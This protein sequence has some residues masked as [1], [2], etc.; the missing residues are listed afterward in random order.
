MT[1]FIIEDNEIEMENLKVL[2]EGFGGYSLIGSADEIKQGIES[3]NCLK[4][5][6][7]VLDIQLECE[8][9]LDH[10]GSL[11]YEPFIIC[12]TLHTE[13]ALQAFEVGAIDYLTKPINREKLGRALD[14]IPVG[15]SRSSDIQQEECL[16]LRNGNRTEQVSIRN[17]V[18][19]KADRD[20]SLVR[21]AKNSEFISTRRMHEW[22][23]LLPPENFISLDRS[24]IVNKALIVS[25]TRLGKNRNATI[26]FK[27]GEKHQIGCAALR[28]LRDALED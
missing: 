10:I 25:Y 2:L 16:C 24:T 3:A 13:H 8:N 9:S 23:E 28:R 1:L 14:R 7:I 26:T 4:P 11:T 27:N 6:I 20:Y 22:K 18:M 12:S 19:V 15:S 17:I 21:D 5:D